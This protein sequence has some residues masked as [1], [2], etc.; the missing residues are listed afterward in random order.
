VPRGTER[1]KYKEDQV[2]Y[3]GI[4][5]GYNNCPDHESPIGEQ[6]VDL[7]IVILGYVHNF[8]LRKV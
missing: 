3:I 5:C 4:Y 6:N 8:D 7:P 1:I 2:P